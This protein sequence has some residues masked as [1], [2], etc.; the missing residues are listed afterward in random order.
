MGIWKSLPEIFSILFMW[1][2]LKTYPKAFFK[3]IYIYLHSHFADYLRVI[4]LSQTKSDN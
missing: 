2:S 4:H 3:P 1:E